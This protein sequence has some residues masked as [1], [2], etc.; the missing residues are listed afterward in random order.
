V[1]AQGSGAGVAANA[2]AITKVEALADLK[3]VVNDPA[4]PFATG[5]EV[6]YEVQVMN[7]GTNVAKQ[8]KVVV[9]F[10]EGI[11]PTSVEG[12]QAKLVPGQ[13]ICEPLAQLEAGEKIAF[14]VK[15]RGESAGN[16]LFRV[17][18]FCTEPE[19]RL[20]SEGT[21]RFFVDNTGN[22]PRLGRK[23]GGFQAPK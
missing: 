2:Q 4:G 6:N 15:A 5:G 22:G 14:K 20:V 8:L 18:V 16:H 17:E 19:T 23:P 13:V 21:T 12:A 7:R 3:L 11:E 9:H 10:S 1:Q